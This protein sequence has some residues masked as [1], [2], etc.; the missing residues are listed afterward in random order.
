MV[1]SD[2]IHNGTIDTDLHV[3]T[4]VRD[5][6]QSPIHH[7]LPKEENHPS[8][9]MATWNPRISLLATFQ[10]SQQFLHIH[11]AQLHCYPQTRT[12]ASSSSKTKGLCRA[13]QKS[14]LITL[15]RQPCIWNPKAQ[16]LRGTMSHPTG[17]MT[18]QEKLGKLL[19]CQL[20]SALSPGASNRTTLSI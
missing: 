10:S 1:E 20:V 18:P 16:G 12:F 11:P 4:H 5:R 17:K 8:V 13:W 15:N 9:V 3:P 19:I 2:L 6:D 14:G 7:H